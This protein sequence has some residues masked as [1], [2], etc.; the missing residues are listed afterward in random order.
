MNNWT[1]EE[2]FPRIETKMG[3]NGKVIRRQPFIKNECVLTST[4]QKLIEIFIG[5]VDP[6]LNFHSWRTIIYWL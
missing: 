6:Y 2:S 1:Q 5:L 3:W 4:I